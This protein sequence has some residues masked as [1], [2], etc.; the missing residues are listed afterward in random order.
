MSKAE[1]IFGRL[2]S[3]TDL[4]DER[5]PGQTLVEIMD[6][7]R[8]LIE[9]HQGVCLYEPTMIHVKVKFGTVCICGCNLEIARMIKE[10]L[11]ITGT[12][13]CVKLIRG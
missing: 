6:D 10:Q 11:I 3:V 1:G 4:P 7:R 8:V 5:L 13:E 9:K 12:V 2:A